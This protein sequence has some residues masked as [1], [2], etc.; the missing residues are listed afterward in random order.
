MY[1]SVLN[2]LFSLECKS[3]QRKMDNF[4]LRIIELWKERPILWDISHEDFKNN[5]LKQILRQN[6]YT[7]YQ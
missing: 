4:E 2:R 6:A 1:Y 5:V 7:L 3:V